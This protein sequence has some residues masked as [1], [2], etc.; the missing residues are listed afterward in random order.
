[1][2]L[3]EYGWLEPPLQTT[4]AIG[5]PSLVGEGRA[6][7]RPDGDPRP[8]VA[9]GRGH[10]CQVQANR[11]ERKTRN[12]AHARED[13]LPQRLTSILRERKEGVYVPQGERPF[14]GRQA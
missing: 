1:M 5:L 7:V 10:R 14:R 9:A 12:S 8:A 11:S 4:N 2:S 13:E 6:E 3:A